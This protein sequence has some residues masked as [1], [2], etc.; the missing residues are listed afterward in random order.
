MIFQVSTLPGWELDFSS[1]RKKHLICHEHSTMLTMQVAKLPS[2]LKPCK[3]CKFKFNY[4]KHQQGFSHLYRVE[5]L[6]T[7]RKLD[8]LMYTFAVTAAV[9]ATAASAATATE[10]PYL[11]LSPLLPPFGNVRNHSSASWY[12]RMTC[13]IT[14]TS[15]LIFIQPLVAVCFYHCSLTALPDFWHL[16]ENQR[17]LSPIRKKPSST[18]THNFFFMARILESGNL[19]NLTLF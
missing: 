3:E 5:I 11:P 6:H 2:W 7:E 1:H 14:R 4:G 9:A 10:T 15:G 18:E 8:I 16:A 17:A 13:P 19:I 12:W